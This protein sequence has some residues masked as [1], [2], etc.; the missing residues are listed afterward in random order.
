MKLYTD[1]PRVVW[2]LHDLGQQTIRGHSGEHETASFQYPDV[3]I[4]DLVAMP[5]S[6]ADPVSV[7]DFVQPAFLPQHA[8]VGTET[9]GSAQIPAS[10]PQFNPISPHP[11]R[12]QSDNRRRT[13]TELGRTGFGD[14]G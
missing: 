13:G 10:L 1:E 11:F 9:H 7:E 14:T 12:H 6:L 5:V 2:D 4:V 8:V 3:V